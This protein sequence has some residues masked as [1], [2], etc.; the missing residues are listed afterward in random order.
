M[1]YQGIEQRGEVQ[2]QSEG[3]PLLAG[4]YPEI[5]FSPHWLLD[6]YATTA[7][8][9]DVDAQIDGETINGSD[10]IVFHSELPNPE[11]PYLLD[12]I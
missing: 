11:A 1:V 10:V 9:S 3:L 2:V 5:R 12:S 8:A 6:R 7:A 4:H